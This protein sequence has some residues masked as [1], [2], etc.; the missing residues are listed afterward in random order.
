ME[1]WKLHIF[2]KKK[3]GERIEMCVCHFLL[4]A[5]NCSVPL[6]NKTTEATGLFCYR[7]DI[8]GTHLSPA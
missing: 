8:T 1:K 5:L 4:V 7:D 2:L 3:H 6:T